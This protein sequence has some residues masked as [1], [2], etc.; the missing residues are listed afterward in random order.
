VTEVFHADSGSR[1][2]RID[3]I[4]ETSFDPT[5]DLFAESPDGKYFF[6]SLRGPLPLSGDPHSSTGST[7]G[8]MVIRVTQGGASG[9]VTAVLPISN[10]DA[11]GVERADAHGIR[12]RMLIK[13]KR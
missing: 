1:V 9:R 10:R 12:S 4:S 5:P 8:L 2:N 3:M 7:P 11:G 13:R 6:A